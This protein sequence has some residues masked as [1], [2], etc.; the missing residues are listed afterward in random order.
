MRR[1]TSDTIAS[2]VFVGGVALLSVGFALIY[3]PAGL[4]VAGTA[5]AAGAFLHE[6]GRR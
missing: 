6:R 2:A 1:L 4:I 5:A 3:L